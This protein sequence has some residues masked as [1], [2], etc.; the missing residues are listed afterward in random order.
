ME[1]FL[2]PPG[3]EF[4][5]WFFDNPFPAP[6]ILEVFKSVDVECYL[7]GDLDLGVRVKVFDESLRPVPRISLDQVDVSLRWCL[8]PRLW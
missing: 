2:E 1:V 7:V 3:C 5:C 4:E 8:H 6:Q